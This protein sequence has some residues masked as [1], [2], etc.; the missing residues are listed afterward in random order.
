MI[1]FLA[2]G[3][4]LDNGLDYLGNHFSC[5]LDEHPIADA[6]ILALDIFFVMQ[7]C[8]LNGH[9]ANIDRFEKRPGV[10]RAGAPDVDANIEQFGSDLDGGIFEGDCPAWVTSD[11]A[12]LLLMS[13]I[14][15]LDHHT[16]DFI[17]QIEA[18]R[19]P[20]FAVLQYLF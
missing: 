15:D 20:L 6:E 19:L 18:L 12:K 3:A 2:A 14:I 7:R 17:G 8:T 10:Y 1:D 4:P 13:Q 16:I 11:R 9:A 5:A